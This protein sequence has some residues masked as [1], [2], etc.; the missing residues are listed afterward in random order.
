MSESGIAGTVIFILIGIGG[1]IFLLMFP[2]VP[3][4]TLLPA[5]VAFIFI[6]GIIGIVDSY[7][8]K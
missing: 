1:I 3:N 8:K 6:G 2:S 5:S 4:H 7:M